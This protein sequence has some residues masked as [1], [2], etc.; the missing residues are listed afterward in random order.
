M[1]LAT[2]TL[3][4]PLIVFGEVIY[5]AGDWIRYRYVIRTANDTCV[6]T[7]RITIEWVNE[8]HVK[9]TGGLEGLESGGSLCQSLTTLLILGLSLEA[10]NPVELNTTTPA[11][12]RTIISPSYTGTYMLEN[13]TVT[14][15]KGILVNL[16]GNATAPVV[17]QYE[18]AIID[19]SIGEL[20]TC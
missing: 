1:I 15:Y 20:K 6:W 13:T 18:V 12:K 2:L 10:E 9:Y 5:K 19:T 8:T 7:F 4:H 17:G 3:L 14:Y 11:S 16:H